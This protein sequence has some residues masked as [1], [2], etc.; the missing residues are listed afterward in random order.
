MKLGTDLEPLKRYAADRVAPFET[1][2]DP[3]ADWYLSA[4]RQIS[5][6]R[7]VFSDE[8][9]GPAE[10]LP[11][12]HLENNVLGDEFTESSFIIEPVGHVALLEPR[13]VVRHVEDI[14]A[15]ATGKPAPPRER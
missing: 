13:L 5:N 10:L 7:F 4:R 1:P 15:Q 6:I 9:R 2:G 11:R 8:E 3:L 12:R 14:V